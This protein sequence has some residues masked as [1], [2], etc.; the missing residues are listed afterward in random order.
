M[1]FFMFY[2]LKLKFLSREG[3]NLKVAD[4][5]HDLKIPY[6]MRQFACVFKDSHSYEQPIHAVCS[7][8]NTSTGLALS[9]RKGPQFVCFDH[10]S[11][12][13]KK[14]NCIN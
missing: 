9:S 12:W 5:I 14:R 10:I 13:A 3:V 1:I 8:G 4:E 7:W 6:N 2:V 11:S